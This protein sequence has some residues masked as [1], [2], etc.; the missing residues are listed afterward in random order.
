M[1]P[2]LTGPEK[3]LASKAEM[4]EEC[5]LLEPLDPSRDKPL[6]PSQ[7]K[8]YTKE[9]NIVRAKIIRLLLLG[10]PLP[11]ET[12]AR[13]I[14]SMGVRL[15][16]A[17]VDGELD[18][19]FAEVA[20]PLQLLW[21]RLDGG[22]NL[23]RARTRSVFLSASWTPHF[24]GGG[25][26]VDG[27]L[28]LN[29][30]FR[31]TSGVELASATIDGS[32]G[33]SGGKFFNEGDTAFN[34]NGATVKGGVF[35][36]EGFEA[37]GTVDLIGANI[38]TDLACDK[39]E[40]TAPGKVAFQCSKA[41]IGGDVQLRFNFRADGEVHFRGVHISG[42]FSCVGG[43]LKAQGGTAINLHGAH[44][45]GDIHIRQLAGRDDHALE[46]AKLQRDQIQETVVVGELDLS[47]ARCRTYWDDEK[48]WPG[49]EK[50]I[51]DG[52]VYDRLGGEALA[53]PARR[54]WLRLQPFRHLRREFRPQPWE[55]LTSVLRAMG[56]EADARRI[57]RWKQVEIR[58]SDTLSPPGRVWNLFLGFAIGHGYQPW[59]A[60]INCV[61]LI[62]FGWYLYDGAWQTCPNDPA[63]TACLME[64]SVP[65]VYA[66][67]DLP[68]DPLPSQYPQFS[69][70]IYSLDVFVPV[71]D[72]HQE[73]YW[74][75]KSEALRL[76]VWRWSQ[77]VLGWVFVSI[78]IVGM[79]GLIRK[80]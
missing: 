31:S 69:P 54:R 32:L 50:L 36:D 20:V 22:I 27:D 28:Y 68:K 52:F 75:P 4:G 29:N 71:F 58:R 16:W 39:G 35:L 59:R 67:L 10:L 65:A 19:E 37:H 12:K 47:G 51:L 61:A 46:H 53:A 18:L 79:T 42:Q 62:L 41:V 2:E 55:Q 49:E 11:G 21:C 66:R 30:N 3:N 25:A 7:N 70:F 78:L 33:C 45:E 34:I 48:T 64:P 73:V 24:I 56:H 6:N 26:R 15:S 8:G 9:D 5:D 1:P 77:I 80:D 60:V 63:G 40:F 38:G 72:L 43:Q 13:H 76:H 14:H 74:Q 17:K 44:V 23:S 57:A